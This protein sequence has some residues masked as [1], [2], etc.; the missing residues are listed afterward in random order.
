MTV[1]LPATVVQP[2]G[3]SSLPRSPNGRSLLSTALL[4]GA[5]RASAKPASLDRKKF[6]ILN[7]RQVLL[8]SLFMKEEGEELA[9]V[10]GDGG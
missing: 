7:E 10:S 9:G 3:A 4:C 6:V 8:P 5:Q 1:A 2:R